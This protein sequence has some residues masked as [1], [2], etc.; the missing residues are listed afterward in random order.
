M[1]EVPASQARELTE[2]NEELY[3]EMWYAGYKD[4]LFENIVSATLDGKN[5]ITL[6]S[7]VWDNNEY[8]MKYLTRRLTK[9]GYSVCGKDIMTI[10]W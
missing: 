5:S 8:K 10:S 3:S 1:A 4:Q 9:L 2:K 7:T 6:E